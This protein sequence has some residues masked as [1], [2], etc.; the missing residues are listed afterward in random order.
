MRLKVEREHFGEDCTLGDLYI[1]EVWECAICE[2]KVR[3]I[4]GAPVESWKVAGETAIPAGTYN[5]VIT[6]SNRFKRD[7]PLVEN[8]P[9]FTGIRIHPGN[10]SEDTAGCL[11]PGCGKTAKGVTNSKVAFKDLFAK[12]QQAVQD[13]DHI[14]LE[15]G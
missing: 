11:L 6:Y 10:T 2:D 7:L 3:E 1:D 9:G 4:Q 8:V 12:L 14:T 13:G 5:V 15:I